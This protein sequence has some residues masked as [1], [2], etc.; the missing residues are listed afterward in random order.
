MGA[1]KLISGLTPGELAR[2][3]CPTVRTLLRVFGTLPVPMCGIC[4]LMYVAI[5]ASPVSAKLLLILTVVRDAYAGTKRWRSRK[6]FR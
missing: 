4:D 3:T 2:G 5:R 6:L 1:Q